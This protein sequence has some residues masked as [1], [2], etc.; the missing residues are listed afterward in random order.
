MGTIYHVAILGST[1]KTAKSRIGS[2]ISI[3]EPRQ[4][5]VLTA[6][7]RS[8]PPSGQS[9]SDLWIVRAGPPMWIKMPEHCVSPPFGA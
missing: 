4:V 6:S 8:S 3:C 7:R 9:S 5:I 1:I 2:W